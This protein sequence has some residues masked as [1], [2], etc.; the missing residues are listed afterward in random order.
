VG[1]AVVRRSAVLSAAAAAAIAA[2]LIAVPAASA[3][4]RPPPIHHVWVIDLENEN[5]GYTFGPSGHRFSPYLTKTLVSD[6]ALLRN[7]AQQ[8]Q[9]HSF[10]RDVYT[11][12]GG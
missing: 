4:F 1:T 8:P 7:Y 11:R 5:F 9:V 10:G 2:L 6:G 12:P 3:E